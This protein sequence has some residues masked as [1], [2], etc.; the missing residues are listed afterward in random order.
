MVSDGHTIACMLAV[1]AALCLVGLYWSVGAVHV[2]MAPIGYIH[3]VEFQHTL[4]ECLVLMHVVRS[5]ECCPHL[6]TNVVPL[7]DAYHKNRP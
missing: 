3:W 6:G 2:G 4:S 5:E 1:L 7:G